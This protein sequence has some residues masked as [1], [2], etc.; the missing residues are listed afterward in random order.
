MV[1]ED[2]PIAEADHPVVGLRLPQ[3]SPIARGRARQV[4]GHIGD[5]MAEAPDEEL[6]TTGLQ[7]GDAVVD[8]VTPRPPTPT[9]KAGAA[10]AAMRGR[11]RIS[12]NTSM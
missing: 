7:L 8:D 2:Q 1:Q 12:T 6:W 5:G 3:L 10:L 4:I 11:C 9:D